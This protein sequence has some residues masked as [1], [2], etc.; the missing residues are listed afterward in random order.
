MIP[1]DS[2]VIVS[3]DLEHDRTAVTVFMDTVLEGF[4]KQRHPEVKTVY[5]FS[6]GPSSQFKNKFIV[7]ILP[8]FDRIVYVQW[9]YFTTSHGKGAVYGIGGTLK[10]MVWNAVSSRKAQPVTDAKLFYEVA[11]MLNSSIAATLIEKKHVKGK[12]SDLDLAKSFKDATAIPG[13]LRFHCIFP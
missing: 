5:V 11:S 7:S 9:K 3:D 1:C 10:Q 13:I 6:D 2:H 12:G 8:T 4:V